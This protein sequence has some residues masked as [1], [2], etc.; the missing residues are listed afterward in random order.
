MKGKSILVL[1]LAV[2]IGACTFLIF[3]S[4]GVI[5][6]SANLIKGLLVCIGL[7]VVLGCAAFFVGKKLKRK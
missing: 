6:S 2:L 4:L 1:I 3:S 5:D 7:P